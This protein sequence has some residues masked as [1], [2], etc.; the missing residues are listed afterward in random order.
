MNTNKMSAGS[1]S[2]GRRIRKISQMLKAMFLVYFFVVPL[3]L[4]VHRGY[5]SWN[6][7]GQSFTSLSAMPLA[8]KLIA[9]LAIVMYLLE[10]VTIYR[11]L[12]LYEKGLIFTVQNARLLKILGNLLFADGLIQVVAPVATSGHLS[13]IAFLIGLVSSPWLMGGLFLIMI[14]LIMEEG[15]KMRDEQA[16]TV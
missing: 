11:L 4:L 7:S 12:S 15:C 13:V 6:I 9:A 1:S 16:L 2:S 5:E 10:I 14:S 3:F 8:P